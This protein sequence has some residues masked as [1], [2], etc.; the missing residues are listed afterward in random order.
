ME[1]CEEY[2]TQ[3]MDKLTPS[4]DFLHCLQDYVL[5]DIEVLLLPTFIYCER[6]LWQICKTHPFHTLAQ[7]LDIEH[8]IT[9]MIYSKTIMSR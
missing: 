1:K 4:P 2:K 6:K 5:F 7:L 3:E 9:V 8:P